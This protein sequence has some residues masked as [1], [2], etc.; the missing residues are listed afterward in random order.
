[1]P[2]LVIPYAPSRDRT[3]TPAAEERRHWS[4]TH[5]KPGE[6]TASLG[7]QPRTGVTQMRTCV[8]ITDK[9]ATNLPR[10]CWLA[11]LNLPRKEATLTCCCVDGGVASHT[12]VQKKPTE[13]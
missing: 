12:G 2:P 8:M 3:Q 4:H 9:L 10:T 13:K 7:D 6:R 5:G 1:M 11:A